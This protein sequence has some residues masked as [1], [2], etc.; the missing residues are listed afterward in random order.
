MKQITEAD[1]SAEGKFSFGVKCCVLDILVDCVCVTR[2]NE[3]LLTEGYADFMHVVAKF[4]EEFFGIGKE[5]VVLLVLRKLDRL[6]A[7]KNTEL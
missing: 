3:P 2:P 7:D 1:V 4:G 6:I 5:I